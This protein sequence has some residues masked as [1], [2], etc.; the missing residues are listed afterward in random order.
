MACEVGS[1]RHRLTGSVRRSCRPMVLELELG[2]TSEEGG[3]RRTALG[4]TPGLA[5]RRVTTTPSRLDSFEQNFHCGGS[6]A[7]RQISGGVSEKGRP[8]QASHSAAASYR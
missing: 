5:M 3:P 2:R 8:A 4:I 1:W 6:S 7:R